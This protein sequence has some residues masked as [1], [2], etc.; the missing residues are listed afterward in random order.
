MKHH[1]LARRLAAAGAAL[2]M[3]AAAL[4]G[5]IIQPVTVYAGQQLGQTDFEN[6]VGLPWHIVESTAGKMEFEIDNGVYKVTIVSP[7]GASRGGEDRWDCQFRH[8]GLKI[9][10]GH[11]YRVQYQ[12]TPSN[13]GK[14]YTKIGNLEGNVEVWHNMSNGYDLDATWDPIWINGNEWKV[15]E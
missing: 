14:Y 4:P 15:V 3:T 5:Q 12:I 13:A 6:G 1:Q 7:G 9:V 2:L 10:A 8:R 11:Q